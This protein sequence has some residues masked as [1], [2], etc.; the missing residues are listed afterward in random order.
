VLGWDVLRLGVAERP[1]LIDFDPPARQVGEHGVL[2][3]GARRPRSTRSFVTVFIAAPVIRTV[4]RIDM[5]STR[6]PTICARLAVESRF[7]RQLG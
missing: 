3:L 2:V 1:D 7:M 5:P 4:D 6:H